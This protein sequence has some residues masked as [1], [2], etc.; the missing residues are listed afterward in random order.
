MA[1]SAKGD[2]AG[3]LR[4]VSAWAGVGAPT[5]NARVCEGRA[6]HHF[7]LLDRAMSRAR[8]AVENAPGDRAAQ[9]LLAEVYIDRGW[10]LRARPVLDG[11]RSA[12]E[13]VEV[14]AARMGEEPLRPE[15]IAREV[16][17]G[18][19]AQA[20]LGL[21]ELFLATG[22][23]LRG[24][25]ILERLRRVEPQNSRV[26]ELLWALGG[27]Y[28]SKESLDLLVK[29]ALPIM[30]DLAAVPEEAEHTESLRS[31][32]EILL[33]PEVGPAAFPSLFKRAAAAP[34]PIPADDDAISGGPPPDAGTEEEEKTMSSAVE[35]P[36]PQIVSVT[37]GGA[38]DT[39]ILMVVG[40]GDSRPMHKRRDPGTSGV[41]NLRDWQASMGVD[42]VGS[43]LDGLDEPSE[44]SELAPREAATP[45]V[46][47]AP[48][49]PAAEGA[50]AAKFSTPI[51]VIEKHPV[52]QALPMVNVEPLAEPRRGLSLGKSL[53]GL[54]LVAAFG[55][56]FL[57]LAALLARAAG[58]LD[59]AR[60]SVD[61]N[62]VLAAEDFPALVDTEK[63]LNDYADDPAEWAELARAQVVIWSEFDGDHARFDAID[64]L[65]ADPTGVDTHRLAYLRAAQLLASRN[66]ASAL[67]AL[68]REP[69]LDDEDRLLRARIQSAL[70]NHAAAIV[71]LD[72]IAARREPRYQ[73]GRA[74]VL[75]AAGR[76]AEARQIAAELA[77]RHPSHVATR[78]WE[79]KLRE[80]TP[81]E[82]ADA[83]AV[84]RRTYGAVGLSP[85]QHGEA[86][87]V[88]TKA[89]RGAG[90]YDRARA[91]AESGLARDGTHRDLLLA[92]ADDDMRQS[93]LVAA[94]SKLTALQSRYRADPEVLSALVLTLLEVDRI[95]EATA[96]AK[97]ANPPLREVL[98]GTVAA[99]ATAADAPDPADIDASTPLGAYAR[100]L[101]AANAHRADAA[102]LASDAASALADASDPFVSRLAL[103]AQALAVTLGPDAAAT[104]VIK[105]R[106]TGIPDAAAHVFLARYWERAGNRVLAAQHFDRAVELEPEL[107]LALYEKGRFYADANDAQDRTRK[108]W[109]DYLALAPTGPR[110][111]RARTSPALHSE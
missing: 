105:W 58:F 108:A 100:A 54:A 74:G 71:E 77:S 14:L 102:L 28:G 26:T 85:R 34:A 79:L 87:W 94:A 22:S 19:D 42:P 72:A 90:D 107:G 78:L 25:G 59:A 103:R 56:M 75:A 73:L 110:A 62:R 24:T 69:A 35:S 84:F 109:A 18:D 4:L 33:E 66:P 1:L 5:V 86:A 68:G 27:D 6:F 48:S 99:W 17:A 65:L 44:D 57:L 49:A 3:V 106:N 52:P 10:P 38:G 8:D 89:W 82:L 11:L 32:G 43:D 16:E 93:E 31:E 37:G 80:G 98:V 101:L 64:A 76:T 96:L 36:P 47:V 40:D 97:E 51:E 46:E 15:A 63:R 104:R 83:A 95:N 81:Q 30:A 67:A 9:R 12:G 53:V 50:P 2:H 70:G 7:R 45:L 111:E 60:A 55:L 92:V 13:N 39:Q 61:L 91:A 23:Q 88:E 29:R 41:L 21:A 20:L